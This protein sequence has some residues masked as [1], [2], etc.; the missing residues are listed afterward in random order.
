[1]G[2]TRTPSIRQKLR[3]ATS[4]NSLDGAGRGQHGPS[5]S[6]KL[7]LLMR[8]K[9]C[10]SKGTTWRSVLIYKKANAENKLA[11][12]KEIAAEGKAEAAWQST[13]ALKAA[14]LFTQFS[15]IFIIRQSLLIVLCLK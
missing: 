12:C 11:R 3:P 14:D 6:S 10:F 1:M 5:V 15:V 8:R 2:N 9:G 4:P 7:Y 13:A